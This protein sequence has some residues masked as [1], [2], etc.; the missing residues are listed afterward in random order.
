MAARTRTAASSASSSQTSPRAAPSPSIW[1]A[2]RASL[3]ERQRR[4][5]AP[6]GRPA[7]LAHRRRI[8]APA[9]LGFEAA[10]LPQQRPYYQHRFL[11]FGPE[12]GKHAQ[13]TRRVGGGHGVAQVEDGEA[14]AVAYAAGD[15]G[16][17]DAATRVQQ[18]Q[19]VDLWRPRAGCSRCALPA[20]RLP[21]PS[22]RRRRP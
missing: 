10:Q 19:P 6:G 1:R 17:A 11:A 3:G 5:G 13:H 21:R 20:A 14:R 4:L 15:I 22:P 2:A 12:A 7:A 16:G 18:R 8:A 9:R